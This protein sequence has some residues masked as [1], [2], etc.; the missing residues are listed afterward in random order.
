MLCSTIC[1]PWL[2]LTCLQIIFAFLHQFTF[3]FT[4][5]PGCVQCFTAGQPACLIPDRFVVTFCLSKGLIQQQSG[6]RGRD[7]KTR[8]TLRQRPIVV[9]SLPAQCCAAA[10]GDPLSVFVCRCILLTAAQHGVITHRHTQRSSG[11]LSHR[12][13]L[14]YPTEMAFK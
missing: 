13:S 10:Q 6:V 4:F 14:H 5:T 3:Q 12:L 1:L 9:L 2:L 11:S 7:R 8:Q